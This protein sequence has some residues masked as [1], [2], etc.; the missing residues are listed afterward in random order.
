MR[1]GHGNIASHA[2]VVSARSIRVCWDDLPE[3]AR[4]SGQ[5]V[6]VERFGVPI[7]GEREL[8]QS[9]HRA[10]QVC[11]T[12]PGTRGASQSESFGWQS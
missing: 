9:G 3:Q 2:L 4:T 7:V 1:I 12:A 11:V 10:D 8:V 6:E 5:I